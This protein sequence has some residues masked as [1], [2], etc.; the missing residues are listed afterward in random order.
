MLFVGST[1]T[2]TEYGTDMISINVDTLHPDVTP[3]GVANGAERAPPGDV[4]AA[5]HQAYATGVA[6][7]LQMM[8][9]E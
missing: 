9:A 4:R 2:P 7:C 3:D 5:N 6:T 1:A 8:P